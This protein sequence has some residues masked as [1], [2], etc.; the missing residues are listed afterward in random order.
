M[1]KAKTSKTSLKKTTP[2]AK[3]A[4]A[5]AT[6]KVVATK[7][8]SVVLKTEPVEAKKVVV[9]KVEPT[10][11]CHTVGKRLQTAEGWKRSMIM[12]RAAASKKAKKI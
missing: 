11:I 4:P 3:K 8:K 1:I 10:A 7:T 12:K 5:P 2:V 6:K 9:P